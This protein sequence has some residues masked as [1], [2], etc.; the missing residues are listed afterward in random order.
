ME[1]HKL[2]HY[3]KKTIQLGPK[4]A[5]TVAYSRLQNKLFDRYWRSRAVLKKASFTWAD[6]V[7]RH[8]AHA[9]KDYAFFWNDISKRINLDWQDFKIVVDRQ[10]LIKDADACVNKKFSILGSVFKHFA[11]IPWHNDIRLQSENINADA[12]FDKSCYF[13]DIQIVSGKDSNT[14]DI[15][16]PWELSRLQYFFKLG[17][18]YKITNDELYAKTFMEH[19]QDWLVNNN[20]LLG[21]N[22]VCPMDVGIRAANIVWALNF[23]KESSTLTQE[24]LQKVSESLY[25][26]FYYLENNWEIYDSRTSNHYF[27]DLLGYFYLCYYFYDLSTVPERASWCFNEI[28]NEFKKQIFEEGTDY[29][30]STSY[31]GL[32]TEIVHHC[33]LLAL[34]MGFVVD[35]S[36]VEKLSKMFEFIDWCKPKN[37]AAIV[38]VGDDDSGKI[39]EYGLNNVLIDHM[40]TEESYGAKHY[41]KF[42]LSIVKTDRIHYTLRHHVYKQSQPSSHFHNDAASITLALDGNPIFIDPGSYI[43]TP[44]ATWRNY[45][46][47]VKN[48]CSFYVKGSELV[49][50][51]DFLFSL[52]LPEQSFSQDWIDDKHP[53]RLTTSH[54]LYKKLLGIT[55]YRSIEYL[56]DIKQIHINDCWK[57]VERRDPDLLGC[58]NFTLHPSITLERDE[59]GYFFLRDEKAIAHFSSALDFTVY[60]GFASFSYGTKT[61]TK[62]L[63]AIVNLMHDDSIETLINLL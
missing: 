3:V 59:K 43:Y 21:V 10:S 24:F 32:V 62:Q 8:K 37:S 1:L 38:R 50:F 40:K 30:G 14:K 20:Y 29:E 39:I 31:H 25:D 51:D 57:S 63:R 12:L 46:R 9:Y 18:A 55:A 19:Y 42:G 27:S 35:Q 6:I 11:S 4:V 34:K 61:A 48:H 7:K 5:A 60:E 49:E 13:K 36:F 16:V 22:W 53:Y 33:Y 58:W 2:K 41:K 23:F 44:S 54:T 47:S 17:Y 52:Q 56:H 28:M 26:H 45:F 15:K